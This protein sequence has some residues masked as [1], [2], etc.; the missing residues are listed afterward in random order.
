MR[1]VL[2]DLQKARLG[3]V[4]KSDAGQTEAQ[5]RRDERGRV[6]AL[7]QRHN[8]SVFLRLK[9]MVEREFGI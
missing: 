3:E 4:F 1:A 8:S 2:A 6:L 9:A 5:I 7:V